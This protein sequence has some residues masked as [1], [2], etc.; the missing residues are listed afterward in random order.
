VGDPRELAGRLAAT[1]GLVEH[2][3]FPPEM[4]S[5]ILIATEAGVEVREGT[6]PD[7]R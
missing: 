3:F 7:S 6:K 4:V 1:P 2:G 5:T